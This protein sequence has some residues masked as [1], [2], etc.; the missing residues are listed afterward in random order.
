MCAVP[1]PGRHDG[2]NDSWSR[3]VSCSNP[4]APAVATIE[5]IHCRGEQVSD[6]FTLDDARAALAA[7]RSVAPD[8]L[9]LP[10]SRDDLAA[11]FAGGIEVKSVEDGL[12]DFPAYVEDVPAYWC[13]R[14][15]E[16]EIQWWHPRDAGFAGRQPI[17]DAPDD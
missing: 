6:A 2:R 8:D 11:I 10:L 12:L 7:L 4:P 13:W 9:R 17:A 1:A 16:H 5:T 3:C 14:V 15:G